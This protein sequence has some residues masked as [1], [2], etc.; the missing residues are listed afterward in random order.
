MINIRK[1]VTST[2]QKMMKIASLIVELI[3]Q[4]VQKIA[5]ANFIKEV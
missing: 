5:D 2:K 1:D 3:K 4:E